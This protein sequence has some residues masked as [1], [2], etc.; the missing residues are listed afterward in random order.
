MQ[1]T[2]GPVVVLA[3]G[4]G[5]ARFLEGLV[6]LV[7]PENIYVIVNV[8]DDFEFCGM[9]ISPDIDTVTYTLAGV[10]NSNTGW[11]LQDDTTAALDQL[12]LLGGP[13]WFSL[14]DKDIG[15]HL[16]RTAR[17]RQGA[18]LSVVTSEVASALG[19]ES[20]IIPVTDQPLRTI[21]QTDEG[22]L[23]FQEYFVSRRQRDVI[24]G[25]QYSGAES[26]E[27]APGIQEAIQSAG[28]IIIAPSNPFLS[29]RPILAVPTVRE[30]LINSSATIVS[31]SPIVAGNA[32][33]GP[34]AAMLCSLGHDVSALGFARLYQ[35]L[36]DVFVIDQKDEELVGS[37]SEETGAKCVIADTI[38]QSLSEKRSLAAT[39]LTAHE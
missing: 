18:E 37:I 24:R 5:A 36:V 26:C 16:Y 22:D 33:K 14:G 38:M 19:V 20:H 23:S 30:C 21:L 10:N 35:D 13:S 2:K 7:R 8:G 31:V 28:H 34:A 25:L 39:V 12:R 11:G 15:T 4:V 17:M 1:D 29:I 9:Y 6:S 27:T 3:G 32:I